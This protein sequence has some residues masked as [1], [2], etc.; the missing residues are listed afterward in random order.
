MSSVKT[1]AWSAAAW[2]GLGMTTVHADA[3]SRSKANRLWTMVWSAEA[4]SSYQAA[5]T[6]AP[7]SPA[8][9]AVTAPAPTPVPASAPETVTPIVAAASDPTVTAPT[10]TAAP[11]V[12]AAA[13]NVA[14]TPTAVSVPSVSAAPT[15]AS[16]PSAAAPVDAFINMTTGPYPSASSLTTGTAQP[17]YDSPSVTQAF[18][19]VPSAQQQSS[20]VQT[21]LQDV[22]HTFQLSGMNPTLTTDPNTPALH[23]ISV[24]S[25]LSDPANANAIGLTN[26]GGD[27]FSFIDKLNYATNPTD[28]AWAIAHN[29]SHE[30]MH[31]FGIGYHPDGGNYVDAA[32]ADWSTLTDPSTQFGPQATQLLLA[33]QYGTLS[34]ST[35]TSGV[36]A[37]LLNPDGTKVDGD[38]VVATPEPATMAMWT[39]GALGGMMVLRRRAARPAA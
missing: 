12:A 35:S 29:V 25:G 19:G 20:F 18:G 4:V 24:A 30:L 39:F 17:W 15:V 14:S 22:Q 36:G 28:L 37:E 6:A 2:I 26:V 8:T 3:I 1:L 33:S 38:E 27:G 9:P 23:T 13:T 5:S 32:S 31:A 10:V 21:V 16:A 7:S 11:M 34:S